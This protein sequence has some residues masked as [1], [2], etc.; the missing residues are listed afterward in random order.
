MTE[1][2][3]LIHP[4]NNGR[5]SSLLKNYRKIIA[6]TRPAHNPRLL[7]RMIIASA[8]LV[9]HA[10]SLLRSVSRPK[11]QKNEDERVDS[12]D[13]PRRIRNRHEVAKGGFGKNSIAIPRRD[14]CW[15]IAAM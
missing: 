13:K 5:S 12:Y 7:Q 2:V 8:P 1:I 10:Q 15:R 6:S 11:D 3:A 4:L 14:G 9:F